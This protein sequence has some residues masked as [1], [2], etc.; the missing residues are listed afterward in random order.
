[1]S[2]TMNLSLAR[3]PLA[4]AII[5]LGG[6]ATAPPRD[7][8]TVERWL[9]ERLPAAFQWTSPEARGAVDARVAELT[10]LPLTPASAFAVAQLASPAITHQYAQL[11]I[12][13]AD[14]VAASR[15][16]NPTLALSTQK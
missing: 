12:A 5:L 10:R 2:L 1:M 9:S 3:L 13:W 8:A 14:V 6:C 4:C 11:G 15:L 7:D 16:D